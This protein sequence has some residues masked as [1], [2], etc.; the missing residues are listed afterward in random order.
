MKEN[1]MSNFFFYKKIQNSEINKNE[2]NTISFHQDKL[3][4]S[5]ED[6]SLN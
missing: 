6:I 5:N 3:Y 1:F 4:L 2:L